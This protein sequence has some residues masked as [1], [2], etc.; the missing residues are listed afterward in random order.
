MFKTL[1]IMCLFFALSLADDT[2]V[3]IKLKTVNTVE[4]C[5]GKGD[6]TLLEELFSID[7]NADKNQSQHNQTGT[8]NTVTRSE[9]ETDAEST[10][11][12]NNVSNTQV[13]P[14]NNPNQ[15]EGNDQTPPKNFCDK[16]KKLISANT[17]DND[18]IDN[19][20]KALIKDDQK[21]SITVSDVKEDSTNSDAESEEGG[22]KIYSAISICIKQGNGKN[23]E[24]IERK[25]S[26]NEN[27]TA[28]VALTES[29]PN[30]NRELF[31]KPET[32]LIMVI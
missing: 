26:G 20:K 10:H 4:K 17:S 2:C 6:T 29:D 24:E 23:S 11:N 28:A 25:N 32:S 16:I 15:S 27:Q 9:E 18:L 30:N 7:L 19:L 5:E 31:K 8:G 21:F 22:P 14:T 13:N 12:Q 1:Y 3:K